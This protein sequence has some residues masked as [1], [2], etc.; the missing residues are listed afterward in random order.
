MAAGF[1]IQTE[2]PAIRAGVFQNGRCVP[3]AA[4]CSVDDPGAR[5][6]SQAIDYGIQQNWNVTNRSRV[7]WQLRC[8]C[9]R[10]MDDT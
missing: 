10:R 5:C 8:L 6:D 7:G 1:R 9:V 3:A 4:K 2:H